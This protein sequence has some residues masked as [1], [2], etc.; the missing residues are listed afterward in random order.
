MYIYPP[1]NDD[2]LE[3]GLHA[4]QTADFTKTTSD[5]GD[6]VAIGD[7]ADV[8]QTVILYRKQCNWRLYI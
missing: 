7:Y 4:T 8:Y 6:Y 2:T 1:E 5:S 3:I